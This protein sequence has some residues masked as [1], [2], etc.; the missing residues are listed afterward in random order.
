MEL[1]ESAGPT[2][3]VSVSY[4]EVEEDIHTAVRRIYEFVQAPF[5]PA[6]E[7]VIDA[8]ERENPRHKEG[9]YSYQLSD[10]GLTDAKINEAFGAY[11]RKFGSFFV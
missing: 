2:L 6:T 5:T 4:K 8:W 7:A 3:F 1:Y 9:A 11:I 10:Y